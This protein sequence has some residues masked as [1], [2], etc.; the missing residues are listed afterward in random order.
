MQL[1]R[2]LIESGFS[3][4]SLSCCKHGG[5]ALLLIVHCAWCMVQQLGASRHIAIIWNGCVQ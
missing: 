4:W 3:T 5:R 1:L 2:I